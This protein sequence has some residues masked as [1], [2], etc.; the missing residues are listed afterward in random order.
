[1]KLY[2]TSFSVLNLPFLPLE[3]LLAS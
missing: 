1:M 3:H 2:A